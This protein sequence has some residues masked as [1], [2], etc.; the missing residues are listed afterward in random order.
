M[1]LHWIVATVVMQWF[2]ILS[3]EL[4][5]SFDFDGF[6]DFIMPK[7]GGINI[8]TTNSSFC[9]SNTT[10]PCWQM[11]CG[12]EAWD[13]IELTGYHTIRIE[14]DV[15]SQ[16]TDSKSR[17]ACILN[18]DTKTEL[19]EP[20]SITL[21]YSSQMPKLNYSLS[22]REYGD[23]YDD[24]TSVEYKFEALSITDISEPDCTS[25]CYWDNLK[26][27]G[28]PYVTELAASPMDNDTDVYLNCTQPNECPLINCPTDADCNIRCVSD[29]TSDVCSGTINC[30]NNG[31]CN[32][33]CSGL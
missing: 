9:P 3:E 21:A 14:I 5:Y 26:F 8:T 32:V 4:I 27:F 30:P 25:S 29:S 7:T 13:Y 24:A 33:F 6:G 2:R 22:L 1:A 20:D 17:G 16:F 31:D 15:T 19:A 11:T 18:L 23:E 12:S 28:I 10:H